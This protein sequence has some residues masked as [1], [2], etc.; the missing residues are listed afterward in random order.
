MNIK[1]SSSFFQ[2]VKLVKHLFGELHRLKS[3]LQKLHKSLQYYTIFNFL[4]FIW[5][6][7]LS[8]VKLSYTAGPIAVYNTGCEKKMDKFQAYTQ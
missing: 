5:H 4:H 7:S 8:V 1:T 3:H 2:Q 6:T